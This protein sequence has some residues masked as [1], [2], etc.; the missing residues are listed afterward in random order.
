MLRETTFLIGGGLL[1]ALGVALAVGLYL[2]GAG[3][4]FANTWLACVLS[5]VLGV[6]FVHVARAEHR[7][8]RAFLEQAERPPTGPPG[9]GP[10]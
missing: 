2:A 3:A 9:S 7:E 5:V 6:F 4:A 1:V 8:R 10:S